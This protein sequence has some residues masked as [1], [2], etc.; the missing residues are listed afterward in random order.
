MSHSHLWNG[1]IVTAVL[2]VA[3][4]LISLCLPNGWR[5][6]LAF[7]LT[8][9]F[10][11]FQLVR[12]CMVW[13]SKNGISLAYG[14]ASNLAKR[15]TMSE[16]LSSDKEWNTKWREDLVETYRHMRE[17]GN[18]GFIFLLEL[19]L[20]GLIYCILVNG[21]HSGF[22]QLSEVGILLAFWAFPAALVHML[23]Q[24][25]ERRFSEDKA[26]EAK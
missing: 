3:V 9:A 11:A 6:C 2:S 13:K 18:S 20:A 7:V 24:H 21:A 22:R 25:L 23:A 12:I 17:H 19:T 1:Y 16:V 5:Y 14:Y 26:D 15:R 8:I 10:S 4:L